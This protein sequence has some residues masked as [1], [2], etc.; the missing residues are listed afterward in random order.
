MQKAFENNFI[1]KLKEQNLFF[2]FLLFYTLISIFII[3]L[4]IYKLHLSELKHQELLTK[5][6]S[7]S[8][9]VDT[10]Q[11]KLLV[12]EDTKLETKSEIQYQIF[13]LFPINNDT[14]ISI[15]KISIFF[16]FCLGYCF[17]LN[18][19]ILIASS[20]NVIGFFQH[21]NKFFVPIPKFR[22]Y[23][24]MDS[25]NCHQ[26]IIRIYENGGKIGICVKFETVPGLLDI[27]DTFEENPEIVQFIIEH[28]N[29]L[30]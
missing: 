6:D 11:K 12:L 4:L 20:T 5:L 16:G 22:D 24:F 15:F 21:V 27:V 23:S 30:S 19:G 26:Y 9:L 3:T 29:L 10:L 17:F 7:L 25:E 1:K 28:L 8:L 14:L 13:Y 18:P 2:Y